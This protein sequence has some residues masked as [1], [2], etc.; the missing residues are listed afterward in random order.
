MQVIVDRLTRAVA[1]QM[2][3]GTY[4]ADQQAAAAEISNI[5]DQIISL[6]NTSLNGSYIFGGT[7]N[8]LP[9]ILDQLVATDPATLRQDGASSYNTQAS[10]YNNVY[11]CAWPARTAAAAS[12][13]TLPPLSTLGAGGLGLDFTSANVTQ[14]QV[15]SSNPRS[16]P[17]STPA[18]RP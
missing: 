12:T 9:A 8:N 14:N 3:T 15:A 17:T 10:V 6:A 16:S 7:R 13:I 2:S 4:Q 18:T 1:E 5:I 11:L